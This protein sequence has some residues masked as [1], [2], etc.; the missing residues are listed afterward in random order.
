MP[1]DTKTTKVE[2]MRAWSLR[3][4]WNSLCSLA[5]THVMHSAGPPLSSLLL[6]VP[7]RPTTPWRCCELFGVYNLHRSSRAKLRAGQERTAAGVLYPSL[8]RRS[9]SEFICRH[10]PRGSLALPDVRAV[11]PAAS[12]L[13]CMGQ[14][15]KH[16]CQIPDVACTAKSGAGAEQSTQRPFNMRCNRAVA[17]LA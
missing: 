8:G 9:V 6:P 1:H 14:A 3:V 10:S 13:A 4:P 5:A 16:V 7:Y 2:G 17:V 12:T 11:M 15:N